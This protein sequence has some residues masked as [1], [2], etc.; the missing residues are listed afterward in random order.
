M[1]VRARFARASVADVAAADP[2]LAALRFPGR[3]RH[4]QELA[5]AA[6]QRDVDAGRTRTH[7]VAPPGSGKTLVG[8]EIVR[9]RAAPALVLVPNTAVQDQWLRTVEQFGAPPGTAAVD[10]HAPIAVLTYQAVCRL[11]DP[12]VVLGDLAARRWTAERAAATGQAEAEVDDEVRRWKGEAAARRAREVAR[13]TAGLTRE[14]ARAEHGEL[15]LGRLLDTGARARLETL[16][17]N[18]VA[19]VV[20]DECH[21]LASLWGY[22]VRA[23]VE[24]LGAVHLVGLTATPPGELTRQEADLYRHLLGGIGFTVPTPAVVR[25]RHLAPYQ[26][27]AW[28]TRPLD[29]EAEWLADHDQRFRELVTA[30]H[31]DAPGPLSFPEWVAT[32]MRERGRGPENAQVGWASFQRGH[33]SLA[34]AGARFLGSAGRA[35]PEDAPRGEGYREEPTLDDWLVL[36]EDYAVRCLRADPSPAA[37]DRHEAIAAALRELGFTLTRRGIRRGTSDV[38]RL[39][40]RSAAKSIAL[41]EVVAAEYAARGVSIRALVLTDTEVAAAAP[42]EALAAVVRGG[43]GSAPDA[44]RALAADVRTAPLRPLLVSG[45]GLRCAAEDAA[46]LLAALA[47]H[48]PAGLG[49]WRAEPDGGLVRLSASSGG[50]TPRVWVP[51]ATHVLTTGGTRLLVGTRAL[52]GEG[53][54]APCV[55]CLVDLTVATTSVAVTQMRGRSLRLD[56]ADP[57]KIASNWDVVCV[58]PE[59]ARGDADYGRFVRKHLHLFAP[60]EDGVIEAG[61][62]HVHPAL[63]PFAPPGPADLG[64]INRQ[65]ARRA[66]EHARARERWAIGT[67]YEGEEQQTLLVR[68]RRGSAPPRPPADVPP[69]SRVDQR[70]ILI[71]GSVAGAAGVVLAAATRQPAMLAALLAMP[72][73]AARALH[74]LAATRRLIDDVLPLD[75]AAQ[76]VRD[77]YRELGELTPR[78]AESLAIEPRASGYLRVWL[79]E[80]TAE[81]ADR[82]TTALNDIVDPGGAPRYLVSRLV[83]HPGAGRALLRVL[84]RRP[85]FEHLWVPVPAD[86]GRRRERAEAFARAWERRLGPTELRFTQRGEAG[87]DARAAAGAQAADYEARTRRIWR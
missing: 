47:V 5:L 50:W 68:P 15:R 4:Y 12:A 58:A 66:R 42:T 19:T 41:T 6:F 25:E 2:R 62:S 70:P 17:S 30:L 52:L 79:R 3:W 54:D 33:P 39:L 1:R 11:D 24:E 13:I 14:I 75:L 53:W 65:M 18:G 78:A 31:E 34:R 76:A 43:S 44:V 32:R 45:R 80:A 28:F 23:V 77:A 72:G 26:E 85:P 83:P 64:E 8:V 49:G 82:F 20:L 9:R 27:L 71:G 57:D 60:S 63:S 40:T 48:A 67:P 74:R 10:E 36:L 29:A 69:V 38:D 59:L 51:L 87:T 16:R 37:A 81:E 56:P 86:L 55:N 7:I 46:D 84:R 22:I 73:A 21:H 35:L 61:P